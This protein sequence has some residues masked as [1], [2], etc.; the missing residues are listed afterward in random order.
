MRLYTFSALLSATFREYY[1]EEIAEDA[2]APPTNEKR[3]DHL[4][5]ATARNKQVSSAAVQFVRPANR[6]LKK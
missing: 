3:F 6:E 2:M 5:A 1:L 4:D